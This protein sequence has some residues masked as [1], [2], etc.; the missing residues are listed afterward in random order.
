MNTPN[1]TGHSSLPRTRKILILLLVIAL[2]L[3]AT[4]G[5]K[6]L[7]DKEHQIKLQAEKIRAVGARAVALEKEN[8]M[9]KTRRPIETF[10]VL[11]PNAAKLVF[12]GF[13]GNLIWFALDPSGDP[14]SFNMLSNSVSPDAIEDLKGGFEVRVPPGAHGYLIRGAATSSAGYKVDIFFK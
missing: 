4:T 5:K 14:P 1:T 6:A 10:A 8:L 13:K 9:L 11:E 2:A 3:I 7:R 12:S